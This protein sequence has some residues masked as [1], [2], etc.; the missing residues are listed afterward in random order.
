MTAGMGGV[1]HRTSY[2]LHLQAEM[3]AWY[4]AVELQPGGRRTPGGR[5]TDA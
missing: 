3:S 4:S 5:S 2:E 1:H